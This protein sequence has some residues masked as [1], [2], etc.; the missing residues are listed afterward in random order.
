MCEDLDHWWAGFQIFTNF[1]VQGS[2]AD[3]TKLAMVALFARLD[4]EEAY[5]L[6]SIH[7]E[8]LVCAREDVAERIAKLVSEVMQEAAAQVFGSEIPFP[9]GKPQ[10]GQ[11]WAG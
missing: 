3:V 9:T 7:D 4:P 2:C 8:L 6:S 11:S 1:L 5:L 10:I